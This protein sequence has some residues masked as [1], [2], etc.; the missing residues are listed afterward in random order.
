MI[1]NHLQTREL[2]DEKNQIK[3]PAFAEGSTNGFF[4]L[5]TDSVLENLKTKIKEAGLPT[6]DG[7]KT[8]LQAQTDAI[9]SEVR[10]AVSNNSTANTT[11]N[12]S[13]TFNI[14]G[15]SGEDVARQI[16]T[17]LV[18]TFSGMSLNAYQRS[19]A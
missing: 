5:A 10:N 3:G 8:A 16:N 15:V 18:N 17:T 11:V 4:P 14:S 12:Q 9:R 2:L 7:I 19:R 6:L 1:L 13:N